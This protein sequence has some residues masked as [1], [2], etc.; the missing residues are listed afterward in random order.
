MAIHDP[1]VLGTSEEGVIEGAARPAPSVRGQ[2]EIEAALSNRFTI[3]EQLGTSDNVEQYLAR[4]VG[5][6][7]LIQLRVLS[8]SLASDVK[9][10]E[11]FYHEARAAAQ[12]SHENV[13]RTGNPEQISGLYF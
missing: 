7:D 5:Q 6:S 4:P 8:E 11:L 1:S 13:P 9:D 12:L 3:V 10:V 2:R